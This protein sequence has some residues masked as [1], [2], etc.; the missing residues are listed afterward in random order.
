MLSDTEIKTKG[1]DIL[2]KY[3]GLVAAER[4]IA[5]I[6]R[7]KMDYT[8]WRVSL[9]EGLSG[10]EISQKAMAFYQLMNTSRINDAED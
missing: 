5:L 2:T 6:Q 1:F 7:E 8:R 4:F 3:L 9:F 10:E